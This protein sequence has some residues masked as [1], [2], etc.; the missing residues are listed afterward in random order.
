M[1]GCVGYSSLLG[2][3]GPFCHCSA[4]SPK[5]SYVDMLLFIVVRRIYKRGAD[6]LRPDILLGALVRGITP[7]DRSD[8][9]HVWR[10]TCWYCRWG[11]RSRAVFILLATGELFFAARWGTWIRVQ[12]HIE[13]VED[14]VYAAVDHPCELQVLVGGDL[15]RGH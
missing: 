1:A 13:R 12:V 10:P 2:Y 14:E 15:A 11:C 5:K 7:D 4:P 3:D 8:S 6:P 9:Y